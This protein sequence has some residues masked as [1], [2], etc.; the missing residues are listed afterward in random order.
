MSSHNFTDR[1]RYLLITL[2]L[3]LTVMAAAALLLT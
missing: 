2:S 1:G 3:L